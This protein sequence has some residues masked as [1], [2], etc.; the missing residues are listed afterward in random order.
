MRLTRR[1]ALAALTGAGIIAAGSAATVAHDRRWEGQPETSLDEATVMTLVQAA[2]ALYP[3]G[4]NGIDAFVR[5]Y[6]EA[7][8]PERPVFRSG[9][10]EATSVIRSYADVWEDS[11]FGGLDVS[12]RGDILHQMGVATADPMA[13]GTDSERVRFYVVNELLY[14]LYTSP[15]GGELVGIENPQGH[16]GGIESYQQDTGSEDGMG[17]EQ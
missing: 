11:T 8:A 12:S 6:A 14:A 3:S 2:E 9:V 1:D 5:T 13:D 4:L 10:T 7:K 16:P 17:D 15:K